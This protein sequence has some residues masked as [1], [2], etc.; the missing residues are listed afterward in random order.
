MTHP[1]PLAKK[2][3]EANS[4]YRTFMESGRFVSLREFVG[5]DQVIQS[6]TTEMA[7]AVK[8]AI[9]SAEALMQ[10]RKLSGL[11]TTNIETEEYEYFM[12]SVLSSSCELSG[13]ASGAAQLYL[14]IV[15]GVNDIDIVDN[16]ALSQPDTIKQE[17][18]SALG[19]VAEYSESE[20]EGISTFFPDPSEFDRET[21]AE[22]QTCIYSKYFQPSQ[23]LA[24]SK[25]TNLLLLNRSIDKFPMRIRGRIQEVFDCFVVGHFF[26]CIVT[27]R[28]LME[29]ILLDRAKPKFG[30]NPKIKTNDDKWQNMQLKKMIEEVGKD[31]PDLA[32]D[33]DFVRLEG[34]R[35]LHPP[36][37]REL[38]VFPPKEGIA[39]KCL[40]IVFD[41]IGQ[42]YM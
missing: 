28:S 6:R 15:E 1:D 20:E 31:Y 42:T 26:A 27:C 8:T 12:G 18:T 5:M 13:L 29:F 37:G 34:N 24:R 36:R 39:K 23:W 7:R 4:L 19:Y 17:V 3:K 30:F 16:P 22:A 25:S 14:D 21:L 32:G 41:A 35:L 11:P 40:H 2:I 38:D 33:L 10:K 9:K